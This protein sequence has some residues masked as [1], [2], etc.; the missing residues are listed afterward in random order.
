MPPQKKDYKQLLIKSE[1]SRKALLKLLKDQKRKEEKL[2]ESEEKYKIITDSIL[3]VIFILDKTG[4]LLFFNKSVENVLGYKAEEVVGKSF[5]KFVPK[6][7]LLKYF[8][9]LKNLFQHKE[10]AKLITQINHRNGNVIDVEING[11]LIKQKRKY[12]GLGVIRDITE[13]K[14]AEEALAT[15]EE[16]YRTLFDLSPS[17]IIVEDTEGKIIEVND[18]FCKLM[19][20]QMNELIN[21]NVKTFVPEEKHQTVNNNLKKLLNEKI[22]E[23]EVVNISKYGSHII[24]QLRETLIT[25][26]NGEK[27]ILS[28]ANDITEKKQA[29][30]ELQNSREELRRLASHLQTV[31]EEER[32]AI[33]RELHDELGQILTSLKL[34]LSLMK[35]QIKDKSI[36]EPETLE[37]E[38][39]SMTN[40][41]D[42]AVAGVRKLITELR[43][44]LLDK[45]GLIAALE[46]LIDDF[47]KTTKL[48]YSFD[49]EFEE[50]QLD[51][52]AK[53]AIFRITQESLTNTAK[54]SGATS[55]KVFLGIHE[56]KLCLKIE[57]NG[58]GISQDEIGG[59]HSF[60]LL[61][62]RER[63]NL[64]GAQ[65]KIFKGE[66]SGTTVLLT[67]DKK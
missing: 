40:L 43:P 37:N 45:L 12:V 9:Q 26:P 3:D 14:R 42:H 23:H 62:M 22:L 61:G 30:A 11:R 27:A 44:E 34:N 8:L 52:N 13:R 6:K 10:I 48:K 18:T 58:K 46:W 63:A 4:K 41:I 21:K 54:Y 66:N 16:Y 53:L 2:R 32:S 17:G 20:Y 31:R 28:I 51:E 50:L 65:F 19:G 29:E 25:L 67:L 33:A 35:R 55:I 39:A 36:Y 64:I 49:C 59:K 24:S 56:N 15:R 7:E 5:T 38:I 47:S 1:K 60:G 57:D